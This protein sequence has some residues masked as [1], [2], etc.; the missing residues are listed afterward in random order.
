MDSFVRIYQFTTRVPEY[1]SLDRVR[2]RT[3]ERKSEVRTGF[4]VCERHESL[5]GYGLSGSLVESQSN[6][7]TTPKRY[8]LSDKGELP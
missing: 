5:M 7:P 8:T 1:L 3:S 4:M 6:P 2:S